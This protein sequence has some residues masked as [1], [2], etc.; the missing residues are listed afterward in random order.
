MSKWEKLLSGKLSSGVIATICALL[1]GSAFPT[2][3]YAYIEFGIQSSVSGRILLAAIRF[4]MAAVILFAFSRFS[5]KAVE[6]KRM[7]FELKTVLNLIILGLFQTAFQ[8]YFFYNGLANTTGIKASVLASS[9]TFFMVLVAHFVYKDDKMNRG[10]VIGLIA[11]FIG[12]VLVNWGKD[13]SWDFALNGEGFLLFTGIVNAVGTVL[14]KKLSKQMDPFKI[15]AWQMLFGSAMLLG[16]AFISG[17]PTLKWNLFGTSLLIYSAF[18][19]AAAFGLWYSL[20]KYH[21]AGEITIFKFIVPISGSAFSVLFIPSEHFSLAI[22][23]ALLL[24]SIGIFSVNK[25]R[26]VNI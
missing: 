8:Y 26:N 5:D 3:K 1:W 4:F 13:F 24:V 15:S 19:S 25:R 2:L 20:L 21:K 6:K 14:A 7:R 23:F 12:I 16:I 11:G 9:G 17:N 10:K 22:I 18:I